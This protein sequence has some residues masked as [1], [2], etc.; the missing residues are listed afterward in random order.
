MTDSLG[1][2]TLSFESSPDELQVQTACSPVFTPSLQ[3]AAMLLNVTLRR[4]VLALEKQNKVKEEEVGV[5]SEAESSKNDDG[6]TEELCELEVCIISLSKNRV[7]RTMTLFGQK[8][9]VTYI[10]S[11]NHFDDLKNFFHCSIQYQAYMST[12]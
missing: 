10:Y 5:V 7:Q 11:N 8:N 4:L 3:C 6:G 9:G 2:I 1:S 12:P